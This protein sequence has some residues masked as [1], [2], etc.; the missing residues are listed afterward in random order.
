MTGQHPPWWP[1]A[2]VCAGVI[3][4]C[5]GFARY[6]Y[7]L[8]VPEF[9][10]VFSLDA[11]GIGILG[12]ASTLG[13]TVGLVIAPRA[14]SASPR[15]TTLAAGACA[16]AGLSLMS[17]SGAVLVPFALGLLIAGSGAGLISPGV[18]QLI[19]RTVDAEAEP[20]AQSWAN[21]GTSLGLAISAFTPT[22][23]FGWR[24]I[25]ISFGLLA[26]LITVIAWRVLPHPA[27]IRRPAHRSRASMRR[28]GA[29]LLLVNSLL[30]G[31][32]S[33]PYWNFSI[34]R[35]QRIGLDPGSAGWFWLTIGLLGPL[36]GVV[37]GLVHR[38]GLAIV[39][40]TTWTLWAAAMALLSLPAPG[41]P[42]ALVS[43]GVF[44]ATYMGLSGICILWAARLYPE[45]PALGVTLSFLGLGAGQT[46]GSPTAGVIADHAGLGTA[47]AVA[48]IIS[49]VA[50][51]Q[52]IPWFR[53]AIPTP[54]S[55]ER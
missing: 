41:L 52:V 1:I 54:I 21:T 8:F 9:A 38:H 27:S 53:R 35:V 5:Y 2:A 3:A 39:N 33:A 17:A 40:A 47:F 36:G 11:T 34:D 43:A 22:L 29:A 42:L 55:Q 19:G 44:G 13:Y 7:G 45:S 49:L 18:A 51:H 12:A 28:P 20:R 10:D 37:G 32:T 23:L 30:L 50:W 14:A 16:A 25:W 31:L 15:G 6:A 26:A 4:V 46:L 48:A 24:C